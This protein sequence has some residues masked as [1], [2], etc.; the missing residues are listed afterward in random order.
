[1]KRF[2]SL[3]FF[4]LC[5]VLLFAAQ[6]VSAQTIAINPDDDAIAFG[7]V[8]VGSASATG[9]ASIHRTNLIGTAPTIASVVLD[10][11]ANFSLQDECTGVTLQNPVT[12]QPASFCRIGV[13]YHPTTVAA[14]AATV[15][16]TSNAGGSPHVIDLSGTGVSSDIDVVVDPIPDTPVGE[17]SAAVTATVTNNGTIDLDIGAIS[18]VGEDFTNFAVLNDNCSNT[19]VAP[20]GNCTFEIVF[21]PNE[22]GAFAANVNVPS[23]DPAAPNFQ[24]LL[25]ATGLVPGISAPAPTFADTVVGAT[26]TQTITVTNT[27]AD[28]S[29]TIGQISVAGLNAANFA[30]DASADGCSNTTVAPS[31]SCDFDVTFAP[32]AVAAFSADA[33]IPSNDP[34]NPN[35]LVD[36]AGNGL[37]GPA[38]SLSTTAIDFLDV[39]VGATSET[40]LVQVTNG[41]TTDLSVTA[42]ALATGTDFAIVNNTCDGATVTPGGSCLVEVVCAPTLTGP[43]NDSL[44]IDSDAASSPDSVT[45]DCNGVIGQAVSLSPTAIDFGDVGVGVTSPSQLVQLTNSGTT[46][47]TVNS[48]ALATGTDYGIVTDTCSSGTVA[49]GGSCLVEVVCTPTT[50]GSLPDSLDFDTDA[51]SSPDSVTLDCEGVIGQAVSLNPAALDFGDVGVGVTSLAQLVQVTNSGTAPL[52]VTTAALVTGTDFQ[53]IGNTCDGAAIAPGGSCLVQLVCIPQTAAALTDSLEITSDADSSPDTV[54][55]DCNGVLDPVLVVNPDA[56]DFGDV[57]VGHTSVPQ[58]VEVIN[59]GTTDLIVSGAS[60]TTGTDFAISSNTCDSLPLAPGSSCII[61]VT[62]TPTDDAALGDTLSIASND[63]NSPATVDLDCNGVVGPVAVANPTSIDFGDV[64]VGNTSTGQ[65]VQFTNSG[66]TD[67]TVTTAA[68]TGG[69]DF[70]ITSNTCDGAVVAPGGSCL[71][72]VACSP[73]TTGPLSDSLDLSSDDPNSPLSVGLDCEGIVGPGVAVMPP[74]QDFGE[75]IVGQTSQ[76]H[77]SQIVNTGITNLSVTSVTVTSGGADFTVTSTTCNGAGLP[78]GGTCIIQAVC[79]PSS[80]GALIGTVEIVSDAPSSPNELQLLCDGVQSSIGTAGSGAFGNVNVGSQGGPNT[81]ILTNEGDAD[82]TIGTLTRVGEDTTQFSL[83]NDECSGQILAP[84]EDCSFDAV[85]TPTAGGSFSDTVL[86]PNDSGTPSFTFNLT[87]TGIVPVPPGVGK[88]QIKTNVL[89]FDLETSSSDSQST[90][91][92][93]IG[94]GSV[95]IAALTLEGDSQFTQVNDCDGQTLA[96]GASCTVT[97]TFQSGGA[98]GS[99]SAVVSVDSDPETTDFLVLLG[100]AINDEVGGGGCSLGAGV[101]PMGAAWIWLLPVLGIG[102]LRRRT[103]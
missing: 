50:T 2:T 62:C 91:I 26:D 98:S 47:L 103:R 97:A 84:G 54:D 32:D 16:I 51:D 36:L 27:S 14:H 28:A 49:P 34:V 89:D 100:S 99:F 85:F 87:G 3:L 19:T 78:P 86:I 38:V 67:L 15:T 94:D 79:N 25:S 17:E 71:V 48:V 21:R 73:T 55:L 24:A 56:L 9:T 7:T 33:V 6:P 90:T 80:T 5:T 74:S 77:V 81:I 93:N 72:Q 12:N 82:L 1:M 66:S 46:N 64:G 58:A 59:L 37:A 92:T 11:T 35:L 102:V 69:T 95:Q 42:A 88:L 13:V 83:S 10:D 39:A 61:E 20:A 31:G 101:T 76:V 4:T 8:N 68:L 30:I 41:G 52:N 44:D 96:P 40:Q 23:S 29:L 45:L 60:L 70:E 22:A 63:P 43:L 75:V 57:G 65:I 18:I 53:I